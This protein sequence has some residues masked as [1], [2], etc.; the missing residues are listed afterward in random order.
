MAL[1]SVISLGLLTLLA[2]AAGL[3]GLVLARSPGQL[4]ANFGQGAAGFATVVALV[5][6]AGLYFHGRENM[7]KIVLHP[8]TGIVSPLKLVGSD[9]VLLHV[10]VTVENRSSERIKILCPALD[11][12][13]L[14]GS[15]RRHL[16]FYEDL[17]GKSLFYPPRGRS[18]FY[19]CVYGY[20][21]KRRAEERSR[22]DDEARMRRAG[23]PREKGVN[24][25]QPVPLATSGARFADFAM[26]PG[27]SVTKT[28][29]EIVDCRYDAVQVIFKV[30]NP[31]DVFDYES[32]TLIPIAK[33]CAV[34]A[35][36]EPPSGPEPPPACAAP[37]SR[38]P[39][40]AT[41]RG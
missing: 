40:P 38:C 36:G 27:E 3:V 1:P 11:L 15:A 41:E 13:G 24:D 35:E 23:R 25:P 33:A 20:E 6:A 34:S 7:P 17:V 29:D 18:Q 16:I 8:P 2:L 39:L 10:A 4:F 31:G 14:D 26:E 37:R 5:C 21:R 22:L 32:K 12:I 19:N 30:P 28:W 9:A